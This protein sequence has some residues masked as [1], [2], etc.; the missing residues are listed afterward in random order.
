MATALPVVIQPG[1]VMSIGGTLVAIAPPEVQYVMRTT[2]FSNTSGAPVS[3]SVWR[4]PAG[5]T[6]LLI[7]SGWPIAAFSTYVS[8]ELANMVLNPN[9]RITASATVAGVID[10]FSSGFSIV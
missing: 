4:E 6:P 9:D 10:V 3:F 8:P 1:I 2:V 5:S 7:I